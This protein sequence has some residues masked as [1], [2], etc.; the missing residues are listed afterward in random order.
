MARKKI[1]EP[2]R[3]DALEAVRTLRSG[4]VILHASDTVWGLA[5]DSANPKAVAK[6]RALKGRDDSAPILVLASDDNM[7]Q[8]HVENVP[9]SAWELYD[10]ADRPT[11]IVLPRGKGVDESILGPGGSLAIRRINE[12]WCEFVIRGLGRPVASSSANLSGVLTPK[13]F[14]EIAPSIASGVDFVSSHR[15]TETLTSPPSFMVGFD[16]EGRFKILRR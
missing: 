1:V 8:H 4:G 10:C 2:W 11:T 16:E 13:S 15:K 12:P 14:S 5:C 3:E 6:I 7:I 9:E